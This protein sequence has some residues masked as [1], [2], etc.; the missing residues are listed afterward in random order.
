MTDKT[1]TDEKMLR[2]KL[3]ADTVDGVTISYGENSVGVIALAI[4]ISKND[5]PL[6]ALS[7]V[8]PEVRFNKTL[9]EVC[10][11][12]LKIGKDKI[13]NELNN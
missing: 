10:R 13:E 2:K 12:M 11:K 1:V 3:I 7:V 4:P 9:D 6:G 8:I 5:Y